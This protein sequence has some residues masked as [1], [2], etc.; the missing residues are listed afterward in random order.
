MK[1]AKEREGIVY[2]YMTPEEQQ[3]IRDAE[4]KGRQW[5]LAC[6]EWVDDNGGIIHNGTAYRIK[7]EPK[8]EPERIDLTPEDIAARQDMR[9]RHPGMDINIRTVI[10]T[11]PRRF[12]CTSAVSV[13]KCVFFC[14]FWFYYYRLGMIKI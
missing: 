11:L 2:S 7:P 6:G 4:H 12:K 14:M 9:F 3:I 5:L 10:S 1:I 8:T 13:R